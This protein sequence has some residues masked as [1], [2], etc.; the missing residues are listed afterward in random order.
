MRS[1]VLLAM[2]LT[3]GL[4][5][6]GCVYPRRGT[7]LTPVRAERTTGTLDAP[8]HTWQLTVVGA[9]IRPRKSGDL[10]WDADDG[11]PDVYVRIFRDDE[12]VFE[13]PTI[14]DTLQPEW[15]ATLPRNFRIPPS[16]RLRIE[17]WD[18]DTVGSDP[19]GIYHHSGLPDNAVPDADA[20]IMLA[21]G[22]WLTLRVSAP[23]P[24]RGVGIDEYEVRPDALVVVRVLPFSP[25]GRAGIEPG[26]RIVGIGEQR[27][28]DLSAVQAAS[29]LSMAA[30]R[31]EGLTV[32]GPDGMERY[33]ELDR[34]YVWLTM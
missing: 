4:S 26:M 16:R 5:T 10:S 33:I 12:L 1:P 11:L 23:R 21:G 34:G 29:A 3:V 8:A 20:R 9:H 18:R 28:S 17:V 31:Q 7:S 2:A 14:D 6:I 13:T 30:S 25:A 24:H 19:V 27:V 32:A 15:N 22:S